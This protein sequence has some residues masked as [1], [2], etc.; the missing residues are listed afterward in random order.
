MFI[1]AKNVSKFYNGQR[2]VDL[3]S[4][5]VKKGESVSI[6]GDKGSGKTTLA[7]LI[8]GVVCCDYGQILIDNVFAESYTKSVYLAQKSSLLEHHTL[9]ENMLIPLFLRGFSRFEA[10]A[11]A[12]EQLKVFGLL[13]FADFYPCQANKSVLRL[14]SLA[15]TGL[16]DANL[17]VFDEP[18]LDI[19]ATQKSVVYRYINSKRLEGNTVLICTNS[20]E[21]AE[22]LTERT[23]FL[24]SR[25]ARS[26]NIA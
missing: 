19:D 24:T 15:Q 2:V 6:M 5:C 3:K 9:L 20:F 25:R 7:K 18:F 13:P 26:I 21:E 11:I 16:F 14:V 10:Q 22:Y 1:E 8:A 23:V 12:K 17:Y 4:F